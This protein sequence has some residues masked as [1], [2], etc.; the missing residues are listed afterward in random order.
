MPGDHRQARNSPGLEMMRLFSA[1]YRIPPFRSLLPAFC[2]LVSSVLLGCAGF[3]PTPIHE[4]LFRTR[5]EEQT[6]KNV[7]VSAAV[8]GAEETEAVFGLPLYSKGIQPIWLE[9]ENK[10]EH[11]MWFAPVSVDRDYFSPL[12]VAYMH[13]SGYS[14]TAQLRMDRYF[15][16]HAIG[17][18]VDPGKVQ[19][20]FIFTNL[21]LGTKAFNVELVGEGQEARTF[22]FLIPVPGLQVDHREVDWTRL[23]ASQEKIS[24]ESADAF[25]KAIEELPCCTTDADGARQADPINVV[26]IG[27]GKDVLFALLR[28]GWDETASAAG[29]DR[30][31]QLPW[32]FRY[33]PVKPL[34]LFGRSQDAAFRKSRST[35]NERN[36]LRLWL[37]PFQYEG[38][39]VWVGQISRIIRRAVWE[40]FILEPDVD[41]ARTYLLQDL[42]YAQALSRYGYIRISGVS[43]LSEGRKSLHDDV[44]FTDGLCLVVWVSDEP[45]SFSEVR[46]EQWE[47]PV[48]ERRKLLLGR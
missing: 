43:P 12:E 10:T 21:D 7:R 30:T 37:S 15:H 29:Y 5:A 39:S 48:L 33:Q 27:E 40:K 9:I 25:R 35:L 47:I 8:L 28:S 34:F 4:S 41:E 6:N 17:N 36:Q 11:R 14:K 16:Q 42:W 13:H 23:R 1:N 3:A 19:S 31:A 45:Q 44:Y 38:K 22:T 24:F 2:V 46:F 20:G 18:I 26:I 32:E